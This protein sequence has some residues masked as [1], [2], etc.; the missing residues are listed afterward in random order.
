MAQDIAL[1]NMCDHKITEETLSISPITLRATLKYLTSRNISQIKVFRKYWNT[2]IPYG[3]WTLDTDGQTLIFTSGSVL[4]DST[5]YPTPIYLCNYGT[6]SGTCPKCKDTDVMNDARYESN[7]VLTNITDA[8]KLKQ[9]VKKAL[10]TKITSNS[11]HQ[12]YGT[13]L[14]QL[15]G[16]RLTPEVFMKVNFTLENISQSLKSY[17]DESYNLNKKETLYDL[18]DVEVKQL[19]PLDLGI[20]ITILNREYEEILTSIEGIL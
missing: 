9:Y 4:T 6:I 11:I 16:N 17:Q 18:A 10:I 13:Y 20:N 15:I 12:D 14:S 19:S 2:I 7:G 3:S 8:N 1:F 5:L